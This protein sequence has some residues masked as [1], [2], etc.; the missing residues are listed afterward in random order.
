MDTWNTSDPTPRHMKI[1]DGPDTSGTSTV[2]HFSESESERSPARMDE[3]DELSEE[4]KAVVVLMATADL[5]QALSL[6]SEQMGRLAES[7]DRFAEAVKAVQRV[8][9][10]APPGEWNERASERGAP[11]R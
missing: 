6:F 2:A 4:A 10:L 11:R 5:Q 8:P 7:L 3:Q 1:A 9:H